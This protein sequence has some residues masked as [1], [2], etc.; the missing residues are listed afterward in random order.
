AS[1]SDDPGA[2]T[3]GVM[4]GQQAAAALLALRTDDGIFGVSTYEFQA[5]GPGVYQPTPPF[6]Y[7]AAQT[8]WIAN[9]TPFTM[10]AADQFLP[11]EGPTPLDSH[12]WIADYKRTKIWGSLTSNRRNDA[13][14]TIGLFWTPNPGPPFTSMLTNLAIS[15]GLGELDSARLFAM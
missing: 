11:D 3:S 5:P 10:T 15:H 7:P 4:V 13:Q 9:M 1:L 12:Q 6:P 8:P 2:I 14:T